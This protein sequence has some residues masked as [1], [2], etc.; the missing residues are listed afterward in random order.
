MRLLN[1][2]LLPLCLFSS[3]ALAFS[4]TYSGPIRVERLAPSDSADATPAND[5][6]NLSPLIEKDVLFSKKEET[7][8]TEGIKGKCS[9]GT[10]FLIV[11]NPKGV[12]QSE[13]P[14]F[15]LNTSTFPPVDFARIMVCEER[16]SSISIH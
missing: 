11:Q 3:A 15:L 6:S 12:W 10:P 2:C 5:S 16:P 4:I 8:P 1:F 14:K 13:K 9:D 7:A